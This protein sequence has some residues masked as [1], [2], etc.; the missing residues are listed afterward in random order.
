MKTFF[1]FLTFLFLA[2]NVKGQTR[3]QNDKY[4]FSGQVPTDWYIYAETKDNPLN[5]SSIIEW[6]LPKVY[7]ELEKTDIENAVSIT[8]YKRPDIKNLDD[9]I[10]FEFERVSHIL[11]SKEIIDSIPYHSYLLITVQKGLK[12]KSK[13]EFVFKNNIGYVLN[14]TATIGTYN[15]NVQKFDSFVKGIQFFEPKE[16]EK[17]TTNNTAIHFDGLYVAKTGE[18]NIPNNKM[19]IYTYIRFY[20]DGTVYTQTVNS[21]D[22]E[23]VIKWFGKNGRFE[24]YGDYKIEGANITFTV[25]NNESTDKA[26]E[27]AKTDKYNGKIIDQNKLFLEVKYASGGLK[28]FWFEFVK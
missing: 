14:F 21:Y 11:S 9:L 4:G 18:V 24:R 27:G 5:K 23:K 1:T 7:S 13:V 26:L 22:P 17:K 16:L 10:K 20:D 19:E 2:L 12:Y 25:T 8:A 3:F 6:G 15:M 28:S